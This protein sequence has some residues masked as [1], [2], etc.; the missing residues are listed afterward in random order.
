MSKLFPAPGS[1]ASTKNGGGLGK[2]EGYSVLAELLF[3][4]EDVGHACLVEYNTAEGKEKE[5]WV[6]W[7]K[8]KVK[9]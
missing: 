9:K 2:S 5:K 6:K 4:V 7:V 3:G 1:N 8:N